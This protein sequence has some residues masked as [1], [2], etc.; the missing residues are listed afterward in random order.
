LHDIGLADSYGC[1]SAVLVKLEILPFLSFNAPCAS[2]LLG[3]T[4][5]NFC[6]HLKSTIFLSLN[7]GGIPSTRTSE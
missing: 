1:T 3:M 6:G 2:Q 7:A 5:Y 4:T